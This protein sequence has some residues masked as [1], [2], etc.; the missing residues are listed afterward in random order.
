V[1]GFKA[2]SF[3]DRLP[4]DQHN[5][6]TPAAHINVDEL[7]CRPF[8]SKALPALALIALVRYH[9]WPLNPQVIARARCFISRAGQD[10]NI[11][12]R[13][14]Y[15]RN[16]ACV[17]PLRWRDN[18]I[19]AGTMSRFS[20]HRLRWINLGLFLTK[21]IESQIVCCCS[22][23]ARFPTSRQ[24]N[25]DCCSQPLLH[26]LCVHVYFFMKRLTFN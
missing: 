14:V 19:T 11:T 16:R 20:F 18:E 12:S 8:A 7:G 25:V 13:I 21:D 15:V 9:Y 17:I 23:P 24:I 1:S 2:D 3:D 22:C 26:R 6:R 10:D 5:A 4:K